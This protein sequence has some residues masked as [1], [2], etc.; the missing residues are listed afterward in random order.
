MLHVEGGL[1]ARVLVDEL[2]R[3]QK[4]AAVPRAS[5]Y[6]SRKREPGGVG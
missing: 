1:V 6:G 3:L 4:N 5:E 2:S